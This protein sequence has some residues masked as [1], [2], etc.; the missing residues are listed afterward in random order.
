MGLISL[1]CPGHTCITLLY[2]HPMRTPS[3]SPWWTLVSHFK[4]LL[5]DSQEDHV[6]KSTGGLHLLS[7]PQEGLVA[8]D[9][10]LPKSDWRQVYRQGLLKPPQTPNS[11]HTLQYSGFSPPGPSCFHSLRPLVFSQLLQKIPRSRPGRGNLHCWG[12]GQVSPES[13]WGLLES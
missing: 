8:Q 1:R 12:R 13:C 5:I 11:S 6:S 7:L 4:E 2:N 9:K 3:K 10:T